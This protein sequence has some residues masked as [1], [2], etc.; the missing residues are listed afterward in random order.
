MY[1]LV[2]KETINYYLN[3]CNNVYSCLFAASKAFDRELFGKLFKLLIKSSISLTIRILVDIYLRQLSRARWGQ[4]T[5]Y[6]FGTSN[7]INQGCVLSTLL[8]IIYMDEL[9]YELERTQIG[10]NQYIGALACVDDITLVCPNIT[11]LNK[12]LE[13]CRIF[14]LYN[15]ITFNSK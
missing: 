10:Y 9:L 8:F 13:I 15:Y 6:Y 12:M 2:Y 11:G 7:G 3:H 4:Q 1:S 5:N 14:V